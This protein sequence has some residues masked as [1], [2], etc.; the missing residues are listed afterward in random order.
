M[1]DT[2][3]VVAAPRSDR[4]A[5]RQLL[6][7]ALDRRVVMLA[8]VPPMVEYEAVLTRPEQ[9]DQTGLTATETNEILDAIAAVGRAFRIR[10]TKWYWTRPSMAK[11]TV[12]LRSTCGT[13][14]TP[15]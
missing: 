12:W 1:L 9:L 13:S 5:S 15:R 8:S 3:V 7:A 10:R 6:L 4:G 14:V 11:Q 2:D